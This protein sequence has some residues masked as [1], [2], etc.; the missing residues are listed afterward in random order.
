MSLDYSDIRVTATPAVPPVRPVA[1]APHDLADTATQLD[2]SQ[3]ATQ[4][5]ATPNRVKQPENTDNT[6]PVSLS[7]EIN[8]LN[9]QLLGRDVKLE[10]RIHHRTGRTY[11]QLVDMQ[12]DKVLKEIP[13]AKMLDIIGKIWDQMGIAVDRK[14]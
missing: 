10:Y 13:S 7:T 4:P 6:S 1:N 8:K 9:E 5:P 2:N 12:T 11:V 3:A 14:G